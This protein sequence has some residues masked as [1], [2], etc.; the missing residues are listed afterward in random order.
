MRRVVF[1][2]VVLGILLS[3]CGDPAAI[4]RAKAKRIEDQT[5]AELEA[6]RAE[7][8]R[9]Q[10]RFESTSDAYGAAKVLL[11]VTFGLALAV[12][13]M[14][15]VWRFWQMSYSVTEAFQ[16][17]AVERARL[18]AGTIK[19]DRETRTLPTVVVE[20][21]VHQLEHGEVF[22]LGEP[23]GPDPQQVTV[24]GQ[25]R[26]LGVTAQAAERIGKK[27]EDARAADALPGVA[28]ALPL[29][30]E[31]DRGERVDL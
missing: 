13:L 29:V 7:E 24:S 23:K 5:Q 31:G 1:L 11:A 14:I 17:Y 22:L 21:A 9:K 3:A 19:V 26:A 6:K 20:G 28:G 8:A 27:A 4:D 12:V 15:V 18:K 2:L 25:V 30:V 10:E 16:V